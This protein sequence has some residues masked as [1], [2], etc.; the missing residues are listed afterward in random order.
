MHMTAVMKNA[1]N[2][3]MLFYGHVHYDCEFTAPFTEDNP[4]LA[5]AQNANKCYNHDRGESWPAQAV[6]PERRYDTETEDCFDV[7]VIRPQYGKVNLVRFGA[8]VDREFDLRTGMSTGESADMTEVAADLDIE[9]DFSAGWPFV[10]QCVSTTSQATDGEEYTCPYNY[11][12]DG[13]QKSKTVKFV[14]SRGRISD[15]KY[16]YTE[17]AG[18][19]EGYLSFENSTVTGDGS[20]YGLLSIPYI[21]GMYL[22]SVSVTHSDT[23]S[24]R[25]N[26]QKG[27]STTTDYSPAVYV[28]KNTTK[29]WDFPLES[30]G[31]VIAPGIGTATSGLRDYAIRMRS[32]NVKLKK[33]TFSYTKTKPE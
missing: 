24:H 14:I 20:T 15:F 1:S 26:I 7:V 25:F 9:L 33:A 30:T 31:G 8:G 16:S 18:D 23:G 32:N 21:E 10:E 5:F 29:T 28:K 2:F 17:P 19:K 22:K 27:F 3:K 6:L 11:E 12:V 13:V 4:I